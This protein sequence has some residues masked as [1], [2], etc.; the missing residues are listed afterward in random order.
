MPDSRWYTVCRACT[1]VEPGEHTVCQ[2]CGSRDVGKQDIGDLKVEI[3]T[4][5][6]PELERAKDA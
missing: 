4:P 1:H 5:T 3:V 2:R 6:S